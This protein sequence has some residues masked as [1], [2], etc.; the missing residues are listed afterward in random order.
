MAVK[1]SATVP[2]VGRRHGVSMLPGIR[3]HDGV[4]QRVERTT[5]DYRFTAKEQDYVRRTRPALAGVQHCPRSPSLSRSIVLN[6]DTTESPARLTAT[7][8]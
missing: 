4:R 2:R 7:P 8:V 1:N 5:R 3:A 6:C